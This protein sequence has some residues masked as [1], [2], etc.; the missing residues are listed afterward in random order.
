MGGTAR[1]GRVCD[2]AMYPGVD[3]RRKSP[4]CR[5][6]CDVEYDVPRAVTYQSQA[7][8]S[9]FGYNCHKFAAPDIFIVT[10]GAAMANLVCAQPGAAVIEIGQAGKSMYSYLAKQMGFQFC[11]VGVTEKLKRF[12]PNMKVLQKCLEEML[13]KI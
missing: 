8:V 5:H 13:R 6:A 2:D 9:S 3:I 4:P 11:A 1:D 12:S 10:H 7:S